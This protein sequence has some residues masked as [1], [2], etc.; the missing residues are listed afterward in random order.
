MFFAYSSE[1]QEKPPG[2]H[3]RGQKIESG[4]RYGQ[5]LRGG[6]RADHEAEIRGGTVRL[7]ADPLL[8]RGL[9]PEAGEGQNKGIEKELTATKP[10]PPDPPRYCLIPWREC[11]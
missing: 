6:R 7:H 5:G 11:S 9:L 10:R 4:S 8:R 3:H 1:G 2:D